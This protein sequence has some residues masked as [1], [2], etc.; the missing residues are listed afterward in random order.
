MCASTGDRPNVTCGAPRVWGG[1]SAALLLVLGLTAIAGAVNQEANAKPVSAQ[2]RELSVRVLRP[3]GATT[4]FAARVQAKPG[5]VLQFR[6]LLS[7]RAKSSLQ[8]AVPQRKA[9]RIPVSAGLGKAGEFLGEGSYRTVETVEIE[10]TSGQP[11]R[12]G[13]GMRQ[14]RVGAG[15]PPEKVRGLSYGASGDSETGNIVFTFEATRSLPASVRGPGG[16]V[17]VTFLVAVKSR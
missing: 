8:I 4:P 12:L 17:P 10:S 16:Q 9:R 14:V 11:V 5:D 15:I 13:N 7:Y 3:E 6:A 1:V 2:K